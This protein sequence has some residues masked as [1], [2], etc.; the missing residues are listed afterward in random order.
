MG[1]SNSDPQNTTNITIRGLST[2]SGPLDPLIVADNFIYDGD[3]NNINPNDVENVT[4][5]K[6]AAATSIWGARAGNGVI[7]I[8]T[9]KGHFN[10]KLHIDFNTDI[11]VT[12][13]PN[14]C[15]NYQLPSSDYIDFEQQ[16]FNKGYY[17]SKFTSTLHPAVQL[18]EDRKNGLISSEDSASEID[19]RDQF[20]KYHYRKGVTQQYALN[21]RGGSQNLA[22]LISGTYDKDIDNL[23]A[24]YSKINLRFENAYRPIKNMTIN[25][26]VY[27]TNS[28]SLSG[29]ANYSSTAA[30]N[31]TQEVP[32]MNLAGANGAAIAVSNYYNLRY[33][34]TLSGGKLLDWNDYPLTN[35]KHSYTKINTE[36]L[37]AHIGLD[38]KIIDGLDINLLYQYQKQ[39]AQNDVISDTADYYARN[40]INMY[41]QLNRTTGVVT[42]VIPL[43]GILNRTY[44]NLSSYNFRGQ[45]NFDKTFN[46]IHRVNAIAGMEVRNEWTDGIGAIYYGYTANPLTYSDEMDYKNRYPTI[47]NGSQSYILIASIVT[48]TDNGFASFF[49][50]ASYTYNGR[51]ILSGSV[52]RDGSNTF[53]ANTNDKWKP[54]WSAGLGWNISKEGFYHLAWL[55]F[56]KLSATYGVSGTLITMKK[57][58]AQFFPAKFSKW[59]EH[60]I[61][62]YRPG[63]CLPNLSENSFSI[64]RQPVDRT[65][66]RSLQNSVQSCVHP[67]WP[68]LPLPAFR[69]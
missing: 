28:N 3:I 47:I 43:G 57:T 63:H 53:S 26:D 44:T 32:Y 36:K 64:H 58:A 55:P 39:R 11:I 24:D 52:R 20:T 40:L 5:L 7:V 4:V 17:N 35:Y 68:F 62:P 31:G 33:L 9:K 25:A 18:F 38:Y 12:D 45:L 67:Y 2:I 60:P 10:E 14:L 48:G 65:Q 69:L 46:H 54:L 51:Y 59:C 42:Y 61:V 6:D 8:T 50:N 16:L 34:D 22:W 30:I 37:L 1:K 41:S 29:L 27:Y 56:L 49:G 23:R 19:N 21:L 15:Y 66:R 13:K